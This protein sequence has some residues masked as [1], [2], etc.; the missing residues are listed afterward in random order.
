[1]NDPPKASTAEALRKRRAASAAGVP[2]PLLPSDEKAARRNQD[3]KKVTRTLIFLAVVVLGTFS[4]VVY[5]LLDFDFSHA[6]ASGFMQHKITYRRDAFSRGVMHYNGYS[7]EGKNHS[8]ALEHFRQAAA[9]GESRAATALGLMYYKGEGVTLNFKTAMRWFEKASNAGETKAMSVLCFMHYQGQ[10]EQTRDFLSA[11]KW[12]RKA[13]DAGDNK[14]QFNLGVMAANGHGLEQDL[15]AS[16]QWLTLSMETLTDAAHA[17][18][19]A[20]VTKM[21][22]DEVEQ[23]QTA[24]EWK[25]RHR[26]A[27]PFTIDFTKSWGSIMG[28]STSTG[29][30]S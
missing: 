8:L 12:C 25:K 6:L 19:N 15:V 1:M 23:G 11:A 17:A 30:V 27:K 24:A 29:K 7:A 4:S 20:L 22:H 18:R 26:E 16:Y 21:T 5:R 14:A 2:P 13:A 28:S 9:E 3:M 10:V